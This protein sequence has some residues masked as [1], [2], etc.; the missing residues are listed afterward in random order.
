MFNVKLIGTSMKANGEYV[1]AWLTLPATIEEEAAALKKIG[2][3][4]FGE[5]RV[6]DC[7]IDGEAAEVDENEHLFLLNELAHDYKKLDKDERTVL[8]AAMEFY[9]GKVE[10]LISQLDEFVLIQ[11][12]D[13]EEDLG[14]KL[15]KDEGLS[16]RRLGQY[17]M[18]GMEFM[19]SRDGGFTDRGYIYRE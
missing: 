14:A 2:A 6:I 3:K 10:A 1:A 16:F 17:Q 4:K 13:S 7:V 11:G 9:G 19:N 8:S 15:A 18:L 5:Y 12:V